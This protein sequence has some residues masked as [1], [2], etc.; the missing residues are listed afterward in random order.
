[1]KSTTRVRCP[2]CETLLE[3]AQEQ[4]ERAGG[5]VRCGN[6]L[7]LFDANSGE[8]EFAVPVLPD[9]RGAH[10]LAAFT[11]KTMDASVLPVVANSA[12]V[13]ALLLLA[14]LLLA[15]A[16][17]IFLWQEQAGPAGSGL[18]I[19]KLVVRKHPEVEGALRVD[20]IL[21]NTGGSAMPMPAL[22]LRFSTRYGEARARRL[23]MPAE[24][25]HGDY[26]GT[27]K[28]AAYTQMQISLS[29]QDPGHDAINFDARLRSVM[30]PA[31]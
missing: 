4:R 13:A 7:H 1:M 19:E 25:L 18:H 2:H 24:Y 23:F 12:S 17:Q 30:K 28:I 15:L 21:S 20:A 9:A 16:A 3:L 6:C 14:A 22:D 29:L 10:P 11:A 27:Q 5:Q 8:L 31:N 26:R